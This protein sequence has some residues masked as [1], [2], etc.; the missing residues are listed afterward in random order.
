MSEWVS[1]EHG[2]LPKRPDNGVWQRYIVRAV[3]THSSTIFDEPEENEYVMSAFYDH[4]QKI[5]NLDNET[6]INALREP[7]GSPLCGDYVTHW[8]QMPKPPMGNA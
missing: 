6:T 1:V 5:W 7:D 3:I 2:N 8:M 4:N